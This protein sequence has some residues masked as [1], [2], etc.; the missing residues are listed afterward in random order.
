MIYIRFPASLPLNYMR[1][2]RQSSEILSQIPRKNPLQTGTTADCCKGRIVIADR[3]AK[4]GLPLR[5]R[6]EGPPPDPPGKPT[7]H[8]GMDRGR[9]AA[10]TPMGMP[11]EPRS[12]AAKPNIV[13]LGRR[14]KT[15]LYWKLPAPAWKMTS[16]RS[17][18]VWRTSVGRRHPGLSLCWRMESQWTA[19]RCAS[20]RNRLGGG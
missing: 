5:V 15:R 2:L 17:L 19:G 16:Y 3:A 9:L 7:A 11:T 6:A 14:S 13:V 20:R 4:Q 12:Q 18:P 10:R 8:D 1:V